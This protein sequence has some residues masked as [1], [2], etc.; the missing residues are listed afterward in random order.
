MSFMRLFLLLFF[1]CIF[2]NTAESQS[3][4]S[5]VNLFNISDNI[6]RVHNG[7]KMAMF[8]N[9]EIIL[10][11]TFDS[12]NFK[13][14]K[15][16]FYSRDKEDVM[17]IKLAP[18]GT[19]LS[20]YH[21]GGVG[22]D[23]VSVIATDEKNN[24]YIAGTF[25]GNNFQIGNLVSHNKHGKDVFIAKFSSEFEP[26]WLKSFGDEYQNVTVS[27]IKISTDGEL[28]ACG[29]F[30]S[31]ELSVDGHQVVNSFKNEKLDIWILK[32][33]IRGT[34]E[35]LKSVGG[36]LDD[37]AEDIVINSQGDVYLSGNSNSTTLYF[38]AKRLPTNGGRDCFIAKYS[39]NGDLMK[40]IGIG[41]QKYDIIQDICLDYTGNVI[42]TGA[43]VG[44][45]FFVGD[46]V[47]VN[48]SGGGCDFYLLKLNKDLEL[49]WLR[50]SG[51]WNSSS[52]YEISTDEKGN[53]YYLGG[54]DSP[55]FE[56][57]EFVFKNRNSAIG[58]HNVDLC[59]LKWNAQGNLLWG[60]NF[61]GLQHDWGSSLIIIKEDEFLLS[62]NTSGKDF[63][64]DGLKMEIGDLVGQFL[65]KFSK[66]NSVSSKDPKLKNISIDLFPTISNRAIPQVTLSI[67]NA[68]VDIN[69]IGEVLSPEGEK[70]NEFNFKPDAPEFQF[71]ISTHAYRAGTY[72]VRVTAGN[73]TVTKTMIIQD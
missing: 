29:N 1:A 26:I 68:T 63:N 69:C 41:S 32:L 53:I 42:A 37:F 48:P 9:G 2:S 20:S 51:N 39:E 58:N 11:A 56:I 22:N 27:D 14:G 45:I 71:S 40:A 28:V 72:F 60:T 33:S 21:I 65:V 54:F 61:G 73:E 49:N 44:P 31:S 38:Q 62:G 64:A 15:W 12:K 70:L 46:T 7:G 47:L 23:E 36:E 57:G 30:N 43:Y 50:S 55:E 18:D 8:D 4:A 25:D 17:L 24:I 6:T 5:W 13:I 66:Q 59:I 16:P 34:I 35:W 52:G 67:N 10:A 3:T 19:I